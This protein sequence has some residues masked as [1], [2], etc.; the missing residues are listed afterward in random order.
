MDL[1]DKVDWR[2]GRFA[3]GTGIID[4]EGEKAAFLGMGG[5]KRRHCIG[6]LERIYKSSTF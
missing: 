2:D 5:Q 1:A 3:K 6:I 4:G